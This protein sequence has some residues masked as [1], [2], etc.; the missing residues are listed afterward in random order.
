MLRLPTAVHAEI[1][2][3]ILMPKNRAAQA[4]DNEAPPC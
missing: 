4:G 2:E 3:G 1:A